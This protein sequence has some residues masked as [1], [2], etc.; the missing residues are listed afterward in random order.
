M[1]GL[2]CEVGYNN[3]TQVLECEG[4]WDKMKVMMA[5]KLGSQWEGLQ[6]N[7]TT[8][9]T[10]IIETLSSQF[11]DIKQSIQNV[12][13]PAEDSR[14][15]REAEEAGEPEPEPEAEPSDDYYCIKNSLAG[16][17]VKSCLPKTPVALDHPSLYR[18]TVGSGRLAAFTMNGRYHWIDTWTQKYV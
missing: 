4:S 17:T 8:G 1:S 16:H 13:K 2:K 15:K 5:E 9:M 18:P 10:G 3:E 6:Q 12:L 14:R 11:N 7:M